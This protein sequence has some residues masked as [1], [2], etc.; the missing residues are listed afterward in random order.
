[1][2]CF[3]VVQLLMVENPRY[4]LVPIVILFLLLCPGFQHIVRKQ[5]AKIDPLTLNILSFL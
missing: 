4:S 3:P 5:G 2:D 1:M